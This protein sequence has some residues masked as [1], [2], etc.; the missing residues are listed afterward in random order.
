[1]IMS[2]CV[3]STVD[4][5]TDQLFTP[6]NPAGLRFTPSHPRTDV[7]V[8]DY[9]ILRTRQGKRE[10]VGGPVLPLVRRIQAAHRISPQKGDGDQTVPAFSLQH[11]FHDAANQRTREW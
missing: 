5:E 2:K 6:G 9:L 10:Y 11:S 8:A 4:H 1:M 7:H 3:Q